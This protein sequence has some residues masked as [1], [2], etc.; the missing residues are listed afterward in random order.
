MVKRPWAAALTLDIYKFPYPNCFNLVG[1]SSISKC[2]GLAKPL[3]GH[4]A[5]VWPDHHILRPSLSCLPT[6]SSNSSS[7]T[8]WEAY[9]QPQPKSWP[10]L[11]AA[12]C[13]ITDN[14]TTALPQAGHQHSTT[15]RVCARGGEVKRGVIQVLLEATC[16]PV[17]RDHLTAA[18]LDS[19]TPTSF[20]SFNPQPA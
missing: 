18:S 7:P 4:Y 3:Q 8:A 5:L 2:R 20:T 12:C 16:N 11:P 1:T 15:H 6:C 13:P 17:S 14:H 9:H 19:Q 10:L